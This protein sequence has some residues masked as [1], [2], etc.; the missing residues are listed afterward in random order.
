MWVKSV[1]AHGV[2]AG[3][4]NFSGEKSARPD[5]V[6]LLDL[7]DSLLIA[8]YPPAFQPPNGFDSFWPYI[9]SLLGFIPRPFCQ[10]YN[11]HLYAAPTSF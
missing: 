1:F 2:D 5:K 7:P 11:E 6:A 10:A 9:H 3:A 4:S 8:A